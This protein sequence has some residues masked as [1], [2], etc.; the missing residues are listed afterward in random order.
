MNKDRVLYKVII[1]VW[2]GGAGNKLHIHKG[3]PY[4]TTETYYI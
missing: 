2:E 1:G 3:E 4:V